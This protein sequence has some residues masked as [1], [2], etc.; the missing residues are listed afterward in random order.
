MKDVDAIVAEAAAQFAAIRDLPQLEN[1]K[2]RYLGKTGR[3]HRVPEGAREA[4]ARG[5]AR[6][7]QP[8]STPPRR[9][10]GGARAAPRGDRAG[11]ARRAAR[12]GGARRH[13]AG[14]RPRARRHPSDQPHLAADRGDLRLD[15][16]RRRRRARDR[17]RLVQLHR[18]QQPGEPSGA[19]DAG[20]VLRRGPGQHRPAAPAAHA[21]QPDAGALRAHAQAADQ[22]DRARAHLS[23]RHATR[24][25]R[26]CSTRSRGCGSTRTSA[27]PT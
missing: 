20:H 15:R 9:D 2:A 16:L 7:R 22:G 27:S 8:R 12:R 1:A 4:S 5:K 17:D 6:P 18:A 13:A 19:L 10:R 24:P 21:H 3:A 23:R 25:T 11:E 26:R 14:P